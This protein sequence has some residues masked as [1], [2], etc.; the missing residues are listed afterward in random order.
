MTS[1]VRSAKLQ[2]FTA[3]AAAAAAL[4]VHTKV[5]QHRLCS[6]R[7]R[8]WCWAAT[9][10]RRRAAAVSSSG[11]AGH[12]CLTP[13]L[14]PPPTQTHVQDVVAATAAQLPGAPPP[15]P[16][17]QLQQVRFRRVQAMEC[18]CSGPIRILL[19]C[20]IWLACSTDPLSPRS[21]P[22]L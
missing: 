16:P 20:C 7:P 8:V 11:G 13:L 4:Y 12:H 6:A 15:T 19:G 1:L 14:P 17:Q 22:S 10:E 9:G 5:G 3:G 21:S 2:A 18:R